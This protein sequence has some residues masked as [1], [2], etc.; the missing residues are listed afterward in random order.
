[1]KFLNS[2]DMIDCKLIHIVLRKKIGVFDT[3]ICL[4]H[5]ELDVTDVVFLERVSRDGYSST[6]GIS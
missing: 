1:M 4:I 3:C 2:S 5:I 6:I